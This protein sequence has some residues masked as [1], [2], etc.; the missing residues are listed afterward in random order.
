M[1]ERSSIVNSEKFRPKFFPIDK[2]ALVML[3][4]K[5]TVGG[6]G[7]RRPI[8]TDEGRETSARYKLAALVHSASLPDWLN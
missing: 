1:L 4:Y 7:G 6:E 5:A 2:T 3:E 8:R